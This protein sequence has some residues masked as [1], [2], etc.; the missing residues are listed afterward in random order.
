M[1]YP[2]TLAVFEL[3]VPAARVEQLLHLARERGRDPA[4]VLKE[5]GIVP[6]EIEQG[7]STFRFGQLYRRLIFWVGDEWLGMF[8]GGIVPVGAF[9]MMC[10]ALL[11]ASN[12]RQAFEL[13]GEFAEVCQGFRVRYWVDD[14]QGLARVRLGPVR[15][16]AESQFVQL[17]QQEMPDA[18]LTSLLAA[19]HLASWVTGGLLPLEGLRLSFKA[20]A[21]VQSVRSFCEQDVQYQQ[22]YNALLYPLAVLSRP[23]VQSHH[24][25]PDFLRTAPHHLV[26]REA[27]QL[28]TTEKVRA[29]L[30]K[31]VGADMPGAEQVAESLHMSVTTLRR[32]LADEN[33]SYQLLKDEC[34]LEAAVSLLACHDL[35][36][37]MISDRLGFD[38]PSAFFRAF[39]KW[40]G[41][42][43]GR[44]RQ[45]LQL[46]G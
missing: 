29:L 41:T 8:A 1:V 27:A 19:H 15:R 5:L 9:R 16:V 13:A 14:Y 46:N 39:K 45:K 37:I 10:L 30:I 34:R 12:L 3:S 17:Q 24:S 31:E 20:G 28:S 2:R 18:I 33:T 23:I 7:L 4:P 42:T 26:T 6:A 21:S 40:T 44:Y 43:P 38:E 22:P 11:T 35:T 25:L 36:N 32:H